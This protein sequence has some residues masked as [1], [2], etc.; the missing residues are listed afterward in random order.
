ME[1]SDVIVRYTTDK[2]TQEKYPLI[3]LEV[4]CNPTLFWDKSRL[5]L[6]GL[7]GLLEPLES[8]KSYEP[9]LTLHYVEQDDLESLDKNSFDTGSH[10]VLML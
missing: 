6:Q 8:V 9:F 3:T 2:E 1:V 5:R 10:G 7:Q 4:I